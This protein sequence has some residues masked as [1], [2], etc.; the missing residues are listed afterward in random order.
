MNKAHRSIL[1]DLEAVRENLFSMSD[2]IWLSIDHNNTEEMKRG[3]EFKATYNEKMV[4]FDALATD[5]SAIVQKFT[6][7]NLDSEEKVGV[8]SVTENDRI[9]RDPDKSTPYT[10]YDDLTFR[11]PHGFILKETA[12]TGVVTW[13]RFYTR[14]CEALHR[15]D[16]DR[17]CALPQNPEHFSSHGNPEFSD[18][19]YR[20]DCLGDRRRNKFLGY[21]P[22][23]HSL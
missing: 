1:K 9:I 22:A 20:I 11:R 6:Q 23:K 21:C 7:I 4:A 2:D 8:E 16:R 12:I 17:F 18:D 10:V 3:C 14:F 19:R 15:L 13:K 5:I